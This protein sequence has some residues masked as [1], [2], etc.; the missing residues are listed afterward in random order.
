MIVGQKFYNDRTH[1]DKQAQ[2][3]KR[4]LP[5]SVTPPKYGKKK[6][7]LFRIC[8]GGHTAILHNGKPLYSDAQRVKRV[9]AVSTAL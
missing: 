8:I 1:Q 2:K 5:S 6:V 7:L 3:Q 4:T 9:G